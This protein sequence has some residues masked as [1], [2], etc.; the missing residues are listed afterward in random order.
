[1]LCN[2]YYTINSF[3]VKAWGDPVNK[4][5]LVTHGILDNAGSFD[6]LIPL[7]PKS[8][9]YICIDFPS[10]G[11]SSHYPPLFPLHDTNIL[12][13]Y[14]LV[15]DYFNRG[16]Y[17]LLGH[18]YGG[19]T[20]N[21]FARMYPEYVEKII[22]IDPVT[23]FLP[24]EYFKKYNTK[25]F[26]KCIQLVEKQRSR[27]KPTYSKEEIIKK[28]ETR[29]GEIIPQDAA[30]SLMLRMIEPSGKLIDLKSK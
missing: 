18:S 27:E 11:R 26:N 19:G 20:G 15:L 14:R 12:I 30:N 25:V 17:I 2:Q 24:A 1:M 9:Y 23:A 13:V 3:T 5:V 22:G 29:Y 8:F 6:K 16:K 21:G 28:L 10:H 4:P 7:L